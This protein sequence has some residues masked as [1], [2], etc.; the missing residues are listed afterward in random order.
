M[1]VQ[2]EQYCQRI[3]LQN[4]S[5]ELPECPS[6][7]LQNCQNVLIL[8][9]F[10]MNSLVISTNISQ[11]HYFRYRKSVCILYSTASNLNICS[12]QDLIKATAAC[13]AT[14][15][16]CMQSSP[17]ATGHLSHLSHHGTDGPIASKARPVL[18]M[19]YRNRSSL[20]KFV[21]LLLVLLTY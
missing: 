14:L 3:V 8:E 9:I 21:L 19:Y 10:F 1:S 16:Q 6:D 13:R 18:M 11:Y 7:T 2:L 12:M 5:A 17:E 4:C 15:H 20:V